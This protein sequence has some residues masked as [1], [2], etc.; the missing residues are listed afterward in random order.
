[1]GVFD[2]VGRILGGSGTK[3]LAVQLEPDEAERS[4]VVAS[5]DPGTV[6][7]VGGDLVLTTKRLVFTPLDV[8]DAVEVLTW[9]LAKAGATHGMEKVPGQIGGVIS[10]HIVPGGLAVTVEPGRDPSALCPPTLIVRTADGG[11]TEIGILDNRRSPNWAT[12]NAVARDAFIAA[13]RAELA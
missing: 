1:V 2:A 7:S 11:T 5:W 6:K 9:G 4:R 8:R 12:K 3:T 13:V 10:Q